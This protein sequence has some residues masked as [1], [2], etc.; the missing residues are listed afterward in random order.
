MKAIVEDL[1]SPQGEHGTGKK[2]QEN[3]LNG[4]QRFAA[5]VGH[6][7]ERR[8]GQEE[9]GQTEDVAA[10][11]SFQRGYSIAVFL[12]HFFPASFVPLGR[13]GGRRGG[14]GDGGSGGSRRLWR[15][16]HRR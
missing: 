8:V 13:R 11:G 10:G 3:D 6:G 16:V 4:V 15:G 5:E 9:Q 14:G 7:E 12:E 2:G 1:K